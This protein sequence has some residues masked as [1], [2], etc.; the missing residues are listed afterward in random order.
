MTIGIAAML[1]GAFVVPA[2]LLAVGHRFR[3]RSLRTRRIF[4]GAVVG[5]VLAIPIAAAA[6]MYPAAEWSGSDRLRG[7]L[8]L[9]SL[10]VLPAVG[11]AWG[12]FASRRDRADAA[13]SVV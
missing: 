12:A 7:A 3:R 10:L 1:A 11:A 4:W 9:W 6:A 2:L 13:S 5:H 8:G